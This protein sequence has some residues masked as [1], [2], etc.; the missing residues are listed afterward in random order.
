MPVSNRQIRALRPYL[1]GEAP[2]E[3][4]EWDMYCPLHEDSTRSASLNVHS[5]QWYCFAGCGGGNL[6]TL[7]RDKSRWVSPGVASTNG[8]P[9]RRST[10]NPE[11]IITEAKIRAWNAVLL[12]DEVMLDEIVSTRGIMTKTVEQFEIGWDRDKRVF[13]IPVRGPEGEIWNVRRYDPYAP[14]DRRKIWSVK[15][16]RPAELYPVSQLENDRIVIGEGEWDILATIQNG[17]PAITRTASAQTWK[18]EWSGQFKDKVV[19]LAHDC[20]ATGQAANRKVA[21]ALKRIAA[22]VRIIGLPYEIAE[23]HGKDLSDFWAEFDRADF[24]RL[25]A[26]ARPYETKK[27]NEPEVVT[28]LETFDS[29]RVAEP[30]KVQVTIKGKKEPG[31]SVPAKAHLTCTRDAGAKCNV[32]PLNGAGG[33]A[34]LEIAPTNPVILAMMDSSA[35]QL[36]DL[37]RA[38]YG[39]V[40]CNRLTIDVEEHQAVEVLFARPSI[41][42]SDGTRAGEY[43]NLKV[44]SAGRHD[45]AP[46]NTVIATGALFPNPRS[47]GNEFL[48]WNVER[49]V[50]SVDHFE[51]RPDIHRMLKRFQPRKGQRPL[52]KLVEIDKQLAAHVTRIIGRPE[53]HA[54]MDLTFHSVLSFKFG[55][56]VV[57]RGWLESVIVGDTRTGKSEAAQQLIRHFAAGEIVGGESASLAGLVGGLQ[58]IGGKDWAVTWGVIPLNDRRLVAVD[59]ISGMHPEDIA[60]MSDVRASGVARLTKIQQEVTHARTRLLWLGNPRFGGMDQFTYGVDALRPL[61][62]NPEDIARFDLA[63]ALSLGDVPAGVINRPVE[64]SGDLRYTSEACHTLLMWAWT[65]QP[66]QIVWQRGAEDAVFKA[67][68]ELGERYVEDPPLIQAAN[69]RIKIARVAAALAARIFSTDDGERLLISVDHVK[70]AVQFIDHLYKMSSF[71]YFD[72]SKERIG[73]VAEALEHRE[74]IRHFLLERRG[75]AKFLRNVGKFRR[76]DLEEIMN[77]DRESAN[78]VINKLWEARMVRKDSG[79]VR[80]EPILHG[81]LREVRW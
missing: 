61:I 20:D 25:L 68:N 8:S 51:M 41:D 81:L 62:G 77:L 45:T 4:G 54:V 48:A 12:S 27:T 63:M 57:H 31:Y 56:Q 7:I 79:D 17:Y 43:K 28:V 13:T 78:A 9:G 75:L 37:L 5:G 1:L 26:E 42:H 55:G 69:V 15:G 11:E 40:K 70:D 21:R 52:K 72:R 53:M 29:G 23:K 71:G 74:E 76:Q 66:E 64:V 80:V 59:E 50:T 30:T 67:A 60:K 14:P 6:T 19:Y 39:A 2:K 3:N 34:E 36:H 73:D 18:S 16:M 33:D 35:T 32:C 44:T 49:Q 47:Q 22:D 58:Q 24:E 38:E 65:R 10:E 46:N